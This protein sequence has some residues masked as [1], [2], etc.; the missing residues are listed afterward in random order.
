VRFRESLLDQAEEEALYSLLIK[1]YLLS[2]GYTNIFIYFRPFIQ[3]FIPQSEIE[4]FNKI[5]DKLGELKFVE[6]K[7]YATFSITHEGVK[8][9]ER[10]IEESHLQCVK[11]ISDNDRAWI[12]ENQK[13][14]YI[15]LKKARSQYQQGID[16][17]NIFKLTGRTVDE[18][19]ILG[20]VYF[21]LQDEGL[22]EFHSLGGRF[23]VTEKGRDCIENNSQVLFL[24][25]NF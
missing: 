16:N 15:I 22:T 9:I 13:L 21:Y 25:S 19:H 3:N 23:I 12:L 24:F 1:I 18:N 8:K 4:T 11:S 6:S 14:R 2:K 17:F 20:K 7:A 10:L 5:M